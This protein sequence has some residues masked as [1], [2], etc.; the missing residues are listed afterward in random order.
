MFE[1]L[2]I[3]GQSIDLCVDPSEVNEN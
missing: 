1:I 2:H 3:L